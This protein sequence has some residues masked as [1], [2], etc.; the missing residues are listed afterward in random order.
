MI[1]FR[2]VYPFIYSKKNVIVLFIASVIS[3]II[4]LSPSITLRYL[5]LDVSFFLLFIAEFSIAFFLYIFYLR[6]LDGFKLRPS[7][8]LTSTKFSIVVLF[9]ILLVQ[10]NVY[11]YRDNLY[12]YGP[13]HISFIAFIIATFLV[14]YYEEII[15]R[16]CIFGVF[17][18]IFNKKYIIPCILTSLS[19]CLMH[20]QYYNI[21]D[22]S[23][24]FFGV[25]IAINS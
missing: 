15:Y 17:H 10:Y 7:R 5:T 4:T 21:L 11:L 13:S 12:H 23:I 1:I 19:F 14:P 2:H 6:K 3:I 9:V 22:Q 16:G 20:G 25:N 24:L 8:D 18:S